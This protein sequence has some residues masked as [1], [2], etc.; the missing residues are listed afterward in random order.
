MYRLVDLSGIPFFEVDG[1][2]ELQEWNDA[3]SG[4]V[5]VIVVASATLLSSSQSRTLPSAASRKNPVPKPP[6]GL[7]LRIPIGGVSS[8]VPFRPTSNRYPPTQ[9][10]PLVIGEQGTNEALPWILLHTERYSNR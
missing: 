8:R 5:G 10:A 9:P 1:Q 7:A 2:G 3:I 6:K 4:L